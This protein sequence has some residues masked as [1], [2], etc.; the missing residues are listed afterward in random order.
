[1]QQGRD[2]V[3]DD[4]E[5]VFMG[6]PDLYLLLRPDRPR[7]TI[8]RANRAYAASTRSDPGALPG[9]G[10]FE[11]F[12]FDAGN[13]GAA[14]NRQLRQSLDHLL[15]ER[16]S[17][18]MPLQKYDLPSPTAEGE[19]L[20]EHYWR[21][22]NT[23]L[24]DERGTLTYILHRVE[25]ITEQV[26]MERDRNRFAD[27]TSDILAKVSFDGYFR[28]VNSSF[29]ETLGWTPGQIHGRP[30]ID[31][32]HPADVEITLKVLARVKD[33][34]GCGHFENRY[35]CRDGNYRWLSWNTQ[36]FPE[37]RMIYC[38]ISD[39]TASR[40]LR[41]IAEG[42]KQALEMSVHGAPLPVI[43]E[44]LALTIE[45]NTGTGVRSSILLLSDDGQHLLTGAAPSLPEAYNS[46]IHG[47]RTGIGEGSCGTV[48]ATG[49]MYM[50][51][52]IASDPHWVDYRALALHH[53]L[54]A[55]WSTPVL[56]STGEVFGTFALYY[57]RPK[58]P[59]AE[60]MQLVEIISRTAG[61][62]IERERNL[63]AKRYFEADLIQARNA[64]EAASVAKSEF[65]A[66][67]S[68]EIRTPMNVIIGIANILRDHE[69]LTAPQ[70]ELMSTLQHSAGSLMELIN[71]LL[72]ISKIEAHSL[73]LER[74]AFNL[75]ELVSDIAG[76]MGIRARQKGLTFVASGHQT[77]HDVFLGDPSRI[78][79]IILNLCSNALKFTDAG[80]VTLTLLCRLEAGADVA[81]VTIAVTDTG[82]GI[83]EEKLTSIFQKFTQADSSINRKFGG[84][85]L[86][87]SITKQLVEE[88]GGSIRVKSKPGTG[89]TFTI[90][91]P[92]SVDPDQVPSPLPGADT[93]APDPTD[94][95]TD[96]ILLVEDFE[97][98]AI[99][100]GHYLKTFGYP[101]EVATNG[102][103]A[104]RM[105]KATPYAAVLMDVQMPVLDG[106]AAT[107]RIREYERATGRRRTPIIAMTAHAMTGDRERCLAADMDDYLPKP[108][109]APEL[110]E[111]LRELIGGAGEA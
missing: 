13:S 61:I 33:G 37:E 10:L 103:E 22:L 83:E 38:A 67:M 41:D 70:N 28:E 97:P 82:I 105:V 36:P 86:G 35:R 6:A 96:R 90:E 107:R 54:L 63:A 46:A 108:F 1:M 24:F 23:P 29:E 65:L 49:R 26:V 19:V 42:Q 94:A 81:F 25:D 16:E 32:V 20:E 88:M 7:Y 45:E 78:R 95:S 3:T 21:A 92:I 111:T 93:A 75:A 12:P 55:C 89:S 2:R 100:A 27:V 15:R 4:F 44:R 91:L 98:N 68:H 14:G 76:M 56:S 18:V 85:G 62:V 48:A 8:V 102:L 58:Q 84:T 53:G 72:D 69:D 77:C 71:N 50:A 5:T 66:N 57:D 104:V 9:M 64:A 59:S 87:L 101:Y 60:E 110:E 47:M 79:Q 34:Q 40:H 74:V 31:L 30:W 51:S 39:V 80:E 52:D 43:L 17:H 11:A 73:Q 109:N 99:I 106:L